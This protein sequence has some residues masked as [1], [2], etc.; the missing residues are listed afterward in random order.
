MG[1]T[2]GFM[3]YERIEEGY[4]PVAERVKSYKEFVIALTPEQAKIQAARCMDCGTP[5]CN[6]GC[7]INN[8]IPD[9]NDLVYRGDWA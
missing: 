4:L 5:F 3:E 7:P 8:I 6:N 1:K 2:T 9:F